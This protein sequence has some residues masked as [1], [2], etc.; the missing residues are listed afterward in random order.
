M[1]GV[2]LALAFLA[3]FA[4]GIDD[5]VRQSCPMRQHDDLLCRRQ[6]G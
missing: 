1:S 3:G 5:H 4:M 2:E 6:R